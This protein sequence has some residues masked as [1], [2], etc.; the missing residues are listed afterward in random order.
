MRPGEAGESRFGG[1]VGRT[2]FWANDELVATG[3]SEATGEY[4]CH[5]TCIVGVRAPMQVTRTPTFTLRTFVC[6]LLINQPT[7]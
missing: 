4:P 1:D 5:V 7:I 3:L 6:T 2:G